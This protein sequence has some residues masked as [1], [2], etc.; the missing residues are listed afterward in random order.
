MFYGLIII[1]AKMLVACAVFAS[2]IQLRKS[3]IIVK[4]TGIW[5]RII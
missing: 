3:G 4:T 5:I 1:P 2:S